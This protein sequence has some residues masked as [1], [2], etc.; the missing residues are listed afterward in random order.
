MHSCITGH[1][2][3]VFA[4]PPRCLIHHCLSKVKASLTS[5]PFFMHTP[6]HKNGW[7][8]RL[9]ESRDSSS[10][11]NNAI[12]EHS[13]LVS[14]STGTFGELPLNPANSARPESPDS[15]P[16]VLNKSGGPSTDHLAYLRESC[17]SQCLYSEASDLMLTSWRQF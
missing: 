14:C 12:L 6:M 16:G 9:G 13:V 1:N 8:A 10:N 2:F 15:L 11:V 5:Q 3:T 7:L 17:S 4:N